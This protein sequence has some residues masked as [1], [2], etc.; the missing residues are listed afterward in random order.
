MA[1]K[2]KKMLCPIDVSNPSP[3]ALE[4]AA[5]IARERLADV[6]LLYVVPTLMMAEGMS[7]TSDFYNQQEASARQHLA[8]LAAQYLSGIPHQLKTEIGDP[9]AEI[10]AAAKNLP[11][12]LVVMTTH[13]RHGFSRLLLGSV[14]ERVMRDVNC[15]VLTLKSYPPERHTVAGWMTLHPVTVSPSDKLTTVVARMHHD[16]AGFRSVPVVENGALVGIITD[17]DIRTN[18][19]YVETTTVDK[20]MTRQVITV[21]PHTSIWDAARLA[22]ERKIG[23]LPVMEAGRLVGIIS[24]TDLLRAFSQ[25]Q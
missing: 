12:D 7:L 11:A 13:G 21:T 5:E 2:F 20:V 19:S 17:R 18:L 16:R 1:P 14:A 23:A 24:T 10:V 9:A 6:H 4:L 3:S 15:P 8:D 22:G 25:L